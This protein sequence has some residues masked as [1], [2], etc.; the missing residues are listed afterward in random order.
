MEE[1]LLRRF[2]ELFNESLL[3]VW[4]TSQLARAYLFSC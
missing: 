3:Y 1:A 4:I 2:N